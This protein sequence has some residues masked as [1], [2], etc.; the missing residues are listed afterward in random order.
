M[1]LTNKLTAFLIFTMLIVG[2]PELTH[3]RAVGQTPESLFINISSR[4]LQINGEQHIIV[5]ITME[6]HGDDIIIVRN[7]RR[8]LGSDYIFVYDITH[9]RLDP[10]VTHSN[11]SGLGAGIPAHSKID[12]DFDLSDMYK[13]Q[14]GNTYPVFVRNRSAYNRAFVDFNTISVTAP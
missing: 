4:N 12:Q 5:C 2:T 13:L 1:N 8:G 10:E 6:N 7:M 9:S 3:P 14:S 11:L